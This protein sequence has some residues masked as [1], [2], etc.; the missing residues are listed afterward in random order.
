VLTPEAFRER[1]RDKSCMGRK[2]NQ[3]EVVDVMNVGVGM[4]R[5]KVGEVK[6]K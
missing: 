3:T 6:R 4:V 5:N 2:L 1:E